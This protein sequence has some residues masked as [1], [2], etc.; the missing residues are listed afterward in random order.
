MRLAF[1]TIG[2]TERASTRSETRW[3]AP[4]AASE[5]QHAD[6][7]VKLGSLGVDLE[8]LLELIPFSREQIQRVL[9]RRAAAEARATQ[10]TSPPP[11]TNAPPASGSA[12][13]S[14]PRPP[15]SS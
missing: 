13:V 6:A 1:L 9:A 3:R 12:C 8:T 2:D 15:A 4:S 5:T 11:A 10:V 14:P 7:L